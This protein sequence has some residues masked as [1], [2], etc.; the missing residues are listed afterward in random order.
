MIIQPII[1]GEVAVSRAGRSYPK[2]IK[3]RLVWLNDPWN[4]LYSCVFTKDQ[5][6]STEP[7]KPAPTDRDYIKS[8]TRIWQ[9]ENLLA[10][11]KSRR[12][13][14]SWLFISLY[15]HDTITG[16]ER[17]NFFV[18]KKEPDSDELVRRARFICENIPEEVWPRDLFPKW[19]YKENNLT[20]DEIGG[21]IRAIASGADQMRQFTASGILMDEVSFWP[22]GRETLSAAKPTIE[23]G[24][25]ITL[26]STA[27]EQFGTVEPFYKKLI[28]D[29]MD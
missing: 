25:R 1:K 22:N 4:F 14:M 2:D 12:L 23:G 6:S 21:R 20:F 7:V 26:L 5:V 27:S 8:T 13:W 10:I 29:R 24:G 16:E 15:L 19:K 11:I 3:E 9:Q 18:S 28:F 17:E